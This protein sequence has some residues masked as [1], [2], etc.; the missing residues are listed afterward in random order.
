MCTFLRKGLL[1]ASKY[2]EAWP[3]SNLLIPHL[4]INIYHLS[5]LWTLSV[6]LCRYQVLRESAFSSDGT[7]W[8]HFFLCPFYWTASTNITWSILKTFLKR[9][10][11]ECV[12]PPNVTKVF[13]I[14]AALTLL[15]F[16][17]N[18]RGREIAR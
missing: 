15:D 14:S 18:S 12:S 7:M 2:F 9:L 16:C 11:K 13:F 3:N 6:Y 8:H 10:L 17:G 4:D 5:V 1:V